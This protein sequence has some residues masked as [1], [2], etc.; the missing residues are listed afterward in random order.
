MKTIIT[1]LSL[2]LV[3]GS[4]AA[5]ENAI[6]ASRVPP[7]APEFTKAG[8]IPHK[9]FFGGYGALNRSMESGQVSIK[10]E[11]IFHYGNP[12]IELY[13]G[14]YYWS[15]RVNYATPTHLPK[16][17]NGYYISEARALVRYRSVIHW[18]YEAPRPVRS[19]IPL[20]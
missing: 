19:S 1:L 10:P 8:P 20:R 7:R 12:T 9:S 3:T 18:L 13:N 14:Q 15:I 5:P 2:A 16:F 6:T 17:V 11:Q 4:F